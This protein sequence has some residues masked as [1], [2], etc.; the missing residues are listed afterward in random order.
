M[1]IGKDGGE[2]VSHAGASGDA[3][4]GEAG[5]VGTL[6]A[7]DGDID[8]AV[9]LHRQ[10]EQGAARAIY[11]RILKAEPEHV[12][13]L[14]FAG[15]LAFQKNE[16]VLGI[17]MIERALALDPGYADAHNNLGNILK[18]ENRLE[19]AER[20]YR[21]AL[22]SV[23]EA[24]DPMINL[25][26]LARSRGA[27]EEAETWYRRVIEIAPE[28]PLVYVNLSGLYDRQGRMAEA[29]DALQTSIDK[30]VGDDPSQEPLHYRRANILL[31]LDRGEE[32]RAIYERLLAARPDNETARHMLAALSGENVPAKP[33]ESYVRNLFDR[34]A[35]SFDEVLDNLDYAAPA[36]VGDLVARLHGE[37]GR[38]R[39]TL[40][41]GCGTGLCG[42][43][44]RPVALSLEGI[45]LS[46]GMLSRA[47][48][49][50]HY[51]R[52][53]E[54]EITAFLTA[55]TEPYDLIVSAD[56]F[57]YFGALDELFAAAAG[58]LAPAGELVF[59]VERHDGVSSDG[60]VLQPHGRYAHTRGG[61]GEALS[62]AGLG[63][64]SIDE[65]VLRKERGAPVH[66]FLV[67]ASRPS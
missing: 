17:A 44:L 22:E 10:G 61:V 67:R 57:C 62:D 37:A 47:E 60:Y 29:L 45:D 7:R 58:A 59:T 21:L 25:G 13:A 39:R 8:T 55:V 38:T 43:Y 46:P 18:L 3:G 30:A 15:L 1:T 5:G 48:V 23:P 56:T 66:G 26:V 31:R 35:Q 42:R 20:H 6:A 51:D 9:A 63:A 2:G 33:A 4:A 34:F 50:G 41:A 14:H 11:D 32:A 19:E 24:V 12:T 53:I 49:T 27:F 40:D 65:V 16:K 54:A 36:L 64:R 28:H 52:L